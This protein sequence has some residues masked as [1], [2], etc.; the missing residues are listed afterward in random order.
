LAIFLIFP[1][2]PLFIFFHSLSSPSSIHTRYVSF[3][4][5]HLSLS[6]PSITQHSPTRNTFRTCLSFPSRR[7]GL[8]SGAGLAFA[9]CL[10]CLSLS[11]LSSWT[12]LI[13]YSMII[14]PQ[15]LVS[16]AAKTVHIRLGVAR[17][18]IPNLLSKQSREGCE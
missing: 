3:T 15:P 12:R 5:S 18:S 10:H 1:S 13:T 14:Q 9:R 2:L 4:S 11:I 6:A 8:C 17:L 16:K 7:P